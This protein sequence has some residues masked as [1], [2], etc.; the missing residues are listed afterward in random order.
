MSVSTPDAQSCTACR[1]CSPNKECN[2]CRGEAQH[3]SS[4]MTAT[5]SPGT[6]VQPGWMIVA[7][8]WAQGHLVPETRY[9]SGWERGAEVCYRGSCSPECPWPLHLHKVPVSPKFPV[10]LKSGWLE[11]RLSQAAEC[12]VDVLLVHI[13]IYISIYGDPERRPSA[14]GKHRNYHSTNIKK[15]KKASNLIIHV[16]YIAW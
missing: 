16:I 14:S 10:S 15:K 5:G 9:C 12:A 6:P 2:L 4:S 11:A 13:Y 7:H 3:R 8:T 1:N